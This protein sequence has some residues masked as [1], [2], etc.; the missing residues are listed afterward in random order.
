MTTLQRSVDRGLE[1]RA[2]IATLEAELAT[3]EHAIKGAAM[4]GDQIELT[5]PDRDGR[6]YLAR[7][8]TAIVPV[9]LTADLITQT[10]AD[11]S[12]AHARIGKAAGDKLFSFYR[13]TITWKILAKT[14]KAFRIEAGHLLGSAAPALITAATSRDKLGLPK[15]QIKVEWDRAEEIK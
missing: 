6:Q 5:D 4:I 10:F 8:I 7:G 3:I 9:V 11:G 13:S 15:S 1:I 2:T 14:G 12:P